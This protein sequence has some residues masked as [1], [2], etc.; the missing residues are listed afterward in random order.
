MSCR[1]LALV[2]GVACGCLSIAAQDKPAPQPYTDADAYQIYSLL[3][4]HEE[5]WGSKVRLIQQE[6]TKT[7]SDGLLTPERC[8]DPSLSAEFGEAVLDYKRVNQQRWL[9]QQQFPLNIPYQLISTATVQAIFDEHKGD[10]SVPGGPLEA[11]WN[12]FRQSTRRP[13]A[14]SSSPPWAST[15]TGPARWFIAV[16]VADRCA[17]AGPSICSRR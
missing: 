10:T 15:T 11:G 9:L 12:A 17:E 4:P 1:G 8:I 16:R 7:S 6:T 5:V 13:A 2:A 3:V 14:S